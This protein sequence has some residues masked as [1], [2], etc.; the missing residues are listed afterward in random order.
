MTMLAALT[1]VLSAQAFEWENPGGE[2]LKLAVPHDPAYAFPGGFK[3]TVRFACDL[4][5]IGERSNHANLFCKGNNFQDGYCVMVRKD[6]ALLVD[7][8]GI[9]PDYYVFPAGFE[10]MREY[11]LEIY[12]TPEFVRIFIDGQERGSYPYA[13]EFDF[14]NSNPLHLGSLGGYTFAGRLPLAQVS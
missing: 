4:D 7:I 13:G 6:G 8:K 9:E 5:K 1:T 12:V 2:A 3:A 14:S 10:S 11:L